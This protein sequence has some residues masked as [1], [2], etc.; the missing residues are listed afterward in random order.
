M[1]LN[2]LDSR[3]RGFTVQT[4]PVLE[5]HEMQVSEECFKVDC[6]MLLL[7]DEEAVGLLHMDHA[8][9]EG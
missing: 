9:L 5:Y 3:S 1:L 6:E 4:F 7:R 8:I 2:S